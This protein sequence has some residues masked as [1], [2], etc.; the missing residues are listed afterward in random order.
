MTLEEIIKQR[1]DEAQKELKM[2][3]D[4]EEQVEGSG[5]KVSD[6]VDVNPKKKETPVKED[7][8]P[9]GKEPTEVKESNKKTS[10]VSDQVSALLE[11][12]GLSEEFKVQAVTIFEAAVTD[13]VLQIE[14]NMK[15]EFEAQLAEAKLEIESDIDGFLSEVVAK[16]QQENEVA[17]KQNFKTQLAEQFIDGLTALIAEH[18]IELPEGKE[19][20]LET[21]LNEVSALKESVGAKVSEIDTL[22]EQIKELQGKQILESFRQKMTQTEFDRFV[23]LTESIEFADESQY[24]KQLTIVME[25]F[26]K[27]VTTPIVTEDVTPTETKVITEDS[28]VASYAQYLAKNKK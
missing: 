11:A 6:E 9:E 25:N 7:V 28:T 12:E 5:E 22:Q 27:K 19:D 15:Q 13:R 2:C 21:A 26:G 24:T 8:A 4:K 18:N 14:E 16:W 1:L 23:Q 10:G 17:I 20:A 3:K